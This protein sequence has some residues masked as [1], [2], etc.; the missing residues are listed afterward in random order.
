MS[1]TLIDMG[2]VPPLFSGVW[3]AKRYFRFLASANRM[4]REM[5]FTV[6]EVSGLS[7]L[8]ELL[9]ASM[10]FPNV[11]AVDE[12]S[13]GYSRITPSPGRRLVKAI[14]MSMRCAENNMAAR[15]ECFRHL[16]EIFRQFLSFLALERMRLGDHGLQLDPRV[17]FN[18]IDRYFAPGSA[19]AW[20]Q[21]TIDAS[22]D[23]RFRS[24]E[25]DFPDSRN[26][27]P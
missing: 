5:G 6:V 23:L 24:T 20:F 26:D 15:A 7:G 14:Y 13:D 12:T 10:S 22:V 8:S 3:N 25:W 4:C 17:T 19:C 27:Q 2:N 11:I 1:G 21:L 18:E 9:S 16:S